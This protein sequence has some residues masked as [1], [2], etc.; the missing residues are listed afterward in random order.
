MKLVAL[1]LGYG[2]ILYIREIE[3]LV[4]MIKYNPD[5]FFFIGEIKKI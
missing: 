3:Y 2:L 5:N 4:L 1:D